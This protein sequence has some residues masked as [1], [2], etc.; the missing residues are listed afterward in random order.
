[1]KRTTERFTSSW[2]VL[3]ATIG[4]AVGTGN[5]WRFPRIAAQ[6]G[7][8]EFLIP[9]LLFLFLWGIPLL[10]AEFALGKSSRRGPGAAIGVATGARHNW[11][12]LFIGLVTT[13][14]TFYYSVV[15]GWCLKYLLSSSSGAL[16]GVD[17]QAFWD[18]FTQNSSQP[19][20]F[21]GLA[22]A[23]GC[24][25]IFR[26]VR[27]GIERVNRFL[28]P[29]L[30][31]LL[32]VAAA[33]AVTLPGAA[34]GLRFLFV[35]DLAALANVEIWLAALTQTAWSTGAGWGL[36]TVLGAYVARGQGF[37]KT[38]ITAALANN[39]ASLI[40]GT[41]VIC[42]VFALSTSAESTNQALSASNE[43]LTFLWLPPL[44][45]AM[46]GGAVLMPLF[47]LTLCCA[48]ISSLITQLELVNRMVMDMGVPRKRSV[49]IVGAVC[50]VMGLPSAYSLGFFRNQ[51]W[52][53]GVALLVSG[54]FV[55]ITV[56][57][58][59]AERFRTGQ[60]M[61]AAESWRVGPWFE[62]IITW[63]IPIEFIALISWW[64]WQAATASG[65]DWWNPFGEFSVGAVIF[66]VGL[67][68][69]VCLAIHRAVW[70]R[71]GTSA[72]SG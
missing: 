42:T 15:T 53:W 40:A 39:F 62:R 14:I 26:G 16:R 19:M 54:L 36:V 31:V 52:V 56:I 60:L 48:A 69:L 70:K 6:N 49:P 20:L 8:G 2:G 25:I 21:H 11:M 47:F 44:F 28:I 4:M 3:L 5:I 1:M 34:E 35:P 23:I 57:R 13:A 51:D 63:I 17:S 58:Y 67:L 68:I 38:G 30:F 7:G 22:L 18:N 10:L 41:A 71:A 32:L 27:A 46:P 50:F 33:R 12:G 64:M 29:T 59:G 9:W 37:V 66:Q 72:D 61:G 55:A 65:T 24:A 45:E 43:G